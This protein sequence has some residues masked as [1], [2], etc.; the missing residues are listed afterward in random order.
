MAKI[1]FF[2]SPD[3]VLSV[4]EALLAAG[5]EI[6]AVVTQPPKPVG[7]K[8]IV[9]P[10]PVSEWASKHNIQVL[11]KKPKEIIQDLKKLNADIGVLES[12]GEILPAEIINLFP[13]GIVNVH[14]SLLPKYRGSSPNQMAILAGDKITGLT[15]IR[16]D[17]KM[18]NG[19]I[20]YQQEEE[21]KNDDTLESLR[22]RLF[23]KSANL[24]VEILPQYLEGK[25][26]TIPQDD[27]QATYTWNTWET[28]QKAYFDINNP[29]SPQVIDR[30]VRAFYPWPVTWTKWSF[31]SAQ[32]KQEKVIKL[33]PERKIQMEGKNPVSFEE[34]KRTYPDF[35]L[36]I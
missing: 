31:G 18:D 13:F 16:L 4:P 26:K 1:V 5:H 8:Q 25:I 24:L 15:V 35:P 21:I 6:F 30:M 32:D 11:D 12:Y 2:G 20:L 36:E 23:Q 22:N 10:S 3:Y 27:S 28:K 19:P 29:P 34:F 33:F 7:R 14:P 17:E 9:T